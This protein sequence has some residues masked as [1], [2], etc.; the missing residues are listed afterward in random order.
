MKRRTAGAEAAPVSP[1]ISHRPK[2]SLC[3]KRGQHRRDRHGKGTPV[4][5]GSRNA[6]EARDG[7]PEDLRDPIRVHGRQPGMWATGTA[8]P[9]P[10]RH[11]QP[12]GSA[13][14]ETKQEESGEPGS[15]GPEG[16]KGGVAWREP[17]T[18]HTGRD[19]G[20]CQPVNETALD[21]RTGEEKAGRGAVL[22]QPRYRLR[23]DA[24]GLSADPQGWRDGH[25]RSDRGGL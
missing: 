13:A 1:E 2:P 7:S 14:A 15:P 11:L 4:R 21:S 17:V 23:M 25:R 6:A 16:G 10:G 24:G 20:P 9:W 22:A 12:I 3:A 5:P 18:G 8:R 19:D